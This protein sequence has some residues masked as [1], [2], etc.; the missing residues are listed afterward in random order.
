M[1]TTNNPYQLGV[2]AIQATEGGARNYQ[3]N[4]KF[5]DPILEAVED[6]LRFKGYDPNDFY[7]DQ[8][9]RSNDGQILTIGHK[10]REKVFRSNSGAKNV[11]R[12][13]QFSWRSSLGAA[14]VR[15]WGKSNFHD[16]FVDLA[17]PLSPA[18]DEVL[19]KLDEQILRAKANVLELEN[20]RDN[21]YEHFASTAVQK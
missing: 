12:S 8:Y 1:K 15:K 16:L 13:L 14:N 21:L 20:F 17:V 9:N 2:H 19:A 7:Y 6:A 10:R 3:A 5:W 4:P 11:S 18:Q